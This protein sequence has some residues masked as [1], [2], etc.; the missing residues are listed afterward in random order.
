MNLEGGGGG[1]HKG[2][3]VWMKGGFDQNTLYAHVKVSYIWN[4][5]LVYNK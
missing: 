1:K 4:Q 2:E 3:L 5:S